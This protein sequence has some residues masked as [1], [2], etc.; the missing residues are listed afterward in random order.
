[1]GSNGS[2]NGL[3]RALENA[4][5]G[6]RRVLLALFVAITAYMG[7]VVV[8]GLHIDAGFTKLLPLR[9]EYMQ[10]YLKHREQFGGANNILIAL[11]A[12]N[13]DIFTPQFFD[14]L[15]QATDEVFFIPGVDRARVRSL[16]TPNVRFTE[17]VEDGISADNVVPADFRR[18][19]GLAQVRKNILKA[20]IVGRLV[21]ND[22]SGGDDQRTAPGDQSDTGKPIDYAEV[23]HQLEQK[24][25]QRF[26]TPDLAST[27]A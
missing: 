19:Q 23:S 6:G 5:F 4:I 11:V 20:G 22:F 15:R 1:V 17:V 7:Y 8:T 10:T 12:R 9:H 2:S 3:L 18:C 25:R 26:E 14:A 13:G 27:C 16:F 21:A 24:L